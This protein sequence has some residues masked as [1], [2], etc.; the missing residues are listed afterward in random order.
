M[1]QV[2]TLRPSQSIRAGIV[3]A[4]VGATVALGG[5]LAVANLWPMAATSD[6]RDGSALVESIDVQQALR[7][8]LAREY[9]ST[10]SS[11]SGF[12]FQQALQQH[13]AREYAARVA[14]PGI[15]V[16]EALREHLAREYR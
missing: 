5:V 8:H 16:Q 13:L 2:I 14:A 1:S 11:V 4:I 6:G 10:G 15:D 12:E 9:S 7:E 3:G